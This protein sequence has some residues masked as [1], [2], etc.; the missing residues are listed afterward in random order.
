MNI[1]RP[2]GLSG[3]GSAGYDD[4]VF[5]WACAQRDALSRRDIAALDWDNLAE[6]IDDLGKSQLGEMESRLATILEHLLK[7]EFGLVREPARGWKR[8]VIVQRSE[9]AR[10]LRRNPSL[11]ARLDEIAGDVYD[12]ARRN[13]LAAF[14]EHEP[15]DLA[16]YAGRLP[17]A[18]PYAARSLLDP[19]F[20][21]AARSSR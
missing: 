8:T 21:P 16:L 17:V 14:E 18:L 13:A 12:D 7:Y 9:L 5:A 20:M 3:D 4:D 10:L 2:L 1:Q 11:A 6:E 19:E 15:D